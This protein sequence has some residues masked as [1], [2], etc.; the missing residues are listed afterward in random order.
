MRTT[1]R[2]TRSASI[3]SLL[4][5]C[6]FVLCAPDANAAP[7]LVRS[8]AVQPGIAQ[9][10]GMTKFAALRPMAAQPL[11][12]KA[13]PG[14]LAAPTSKSGN[15]KTAKLRIAAAQW[16]GISCVPFAR[17][18][19]GLAVK[20]NAHAW[21]DSAAGTYARGARPEA[22]SVLNFQS[23]QRMRLGHVSV[24]ARVID[25]RTVEVDHANWAGPGM[26]KGQVVRGVPVIDVSER[27]DWSAV[28]VGLGHTGSFGSIYPTYGFIY[29]RPDQGVMVANTLARPGT[30]P[31]PRYSEVAEAPASRGAP[32]R[33]NSV[34]FIDAPA[35][36]LR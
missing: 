33:V 36:T 5:L 13:R 16:G 17:A 23:T 4:A 21:W 27:N 8:A 3:T 29:D 26:R 18:A 22:G 32:L 28:Q 24:V 11:R 1:E 9:S 20:G 19:T 12:V 2:V 25:A 30:N 31:G 14:Q 6:G 7:Q 10:A 15:I 35:R 34:S